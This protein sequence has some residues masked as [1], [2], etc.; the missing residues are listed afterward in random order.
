MVEQSLMHLKKNPKKEIRNSDH[1][2]YL[3]PKAPEKKTGFHPKT[4]SRYGNCV[5]LH[6]VLEDTLLSSQTNA[7]KRSQPNVTKRSH[8]R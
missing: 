3:D 5:V 2:K 6:V 8:T 7:T 4:P 1:M